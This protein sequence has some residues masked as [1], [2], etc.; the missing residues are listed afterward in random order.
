MSKKTILLGVTGS[1]ASYKAADLISDFTKKGHEVFVIMT[2]EAAEFITPLTLQTLSG[3]KVYSDMFGIPEEW[4]TKHVS[5]AKKADL[6]LIAPATANIIGKLACGICDDLLTCTATASEAQ[7]LIAPAM[8]DVMYKNKIVQK[9]IARLKGIG[10]EFV[11]PKKGRLACGYE[12]IGCMAD[13][14][15]IVR[16]IE[17]LVK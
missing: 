3:N 17:K 15:E 16:A 6:I 1:I 14:D 5:L 11:G 7:V 13:V 9:N 12:A 8:N 10:Y 4:D 2:K